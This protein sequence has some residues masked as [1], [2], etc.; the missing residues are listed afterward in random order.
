MRLISYRFDGQDRYGVVTDDGVV[1]MSTRLGARAPTL[2][3]AIAAG[4]LDEM[5]QLAE[6]ATAATVD[7]AVESVELDR[8]STRLN[9]SH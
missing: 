2:R 8:K 4:C 5:K 6:G 7:C 3:D 9:S 1:D